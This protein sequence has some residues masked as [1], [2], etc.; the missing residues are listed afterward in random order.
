MRLSFALGPITDRWDKAVGDS[1]SSWL[2]FLRSTIAA[3]TTNR[4]SLPCFEKHAK[5]AK[6]CKKCKNDISDMHAHCR[7]AS[8]ASSKCP[9]L[10]TTSIEMLDHGTTSGGSNMPSRNR[11]DMRLLTAASTSAIVIKPCDDTTQHRKTS[12]KKARRQI[13][14]LPHETAFHPRYLGERFVEG[15]VR[16]AAVGVGAG[17]QCRSC[18]LRECVVVEVL[19]H[20][21]VHGA[22]VTDDVAVKGPLTP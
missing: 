8:K 6:K 7:A 10:P 13:P 16:R 21:V 1:G 2:S 14:L 15:V 4:C 20:D 18:S 19:A 22:A 9:A 5:N 12:I 17:C 11:T 3:R